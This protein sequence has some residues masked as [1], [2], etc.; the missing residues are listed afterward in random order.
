[1]RRGGSGRGY[2]KIKSLDIV[3]CETKD[4][5]FT[6]QPYGSRNRNFQFLSMNFYLYSNKLYHIMQLYIR[7]GYKAHP[8]ETHYK[9]QYI[10]DTRFYNDYFIVHYRTFNKSVV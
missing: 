9:I 5:G 4:I 1:M 3:V 7:L 8:V 2:F 6:K 10:F